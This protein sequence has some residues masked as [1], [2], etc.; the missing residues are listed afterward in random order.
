[1]LLPCANPTVQHKLHQ[2][3][4]SIDTGGLDYPTKKLTQQKFIAKAA[5][6]RKQTHAGICKASR[7]L[8][9]GQPTNKE[10]QYNTVALEGVHLPLPSCMPPAD[11]P[12]QQHSMQ[13]NCIYKGTTAHLHLPSCMPPADRPA[14][15]ILL[16]PS[17]F[18]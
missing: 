5:Q 17:S 18:T 6:Q 12:A 14:R 3:M 11:R 7:G 2:S 10:H 16:S 4:P 8:L 9:T 15:S 1:M 13:Q